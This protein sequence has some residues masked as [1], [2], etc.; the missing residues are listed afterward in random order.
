MPI[1]FAMSYE[2]SHDL[3]HSVQLA[4]QLQANEAELRLSEQRMSLAA[5]A[6]DLRLWEWDIVHD[7]IW[8][9]DKQRMLFGIALSEKISF[10]HFLSV[11]HDEDRERVRLSVEKS[12]KGNGHFES[13]YR[14]V[15]PDGRIIW[16][17]ARGRIE[18]DNGQPL[19]MLGV[20]IDIT[21]RKQAELEVQQQRNELTHLSRVNL[22]GELSGS[23]AHELNQPLAAILSNAQAAQRFLARDKADIA[24]V[25]DILKDIV[26]EDRRAGAII[27]RLRILLRKGEVRRLPLDVNKVVKDVLKLLQSDLVNQSI[28]V[29][30][31]LDQKLPVVNGDRVQLQQVLLN[32]ILNACEAMSRSKTSNRQLSVR[33]ERADTD[34]IKVSVG[35]RGPGISP[36]SLESIFQP[37]FTTKKQGMGLG[38]TICRNIISAHEGQLRASNSVGGGAVLHFTLPA[39][40]GVSV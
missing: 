15:Y 40:P 14:I 6:A 32:L 3:F 18:F 37:F 28:T 20:S 12:L 8:S 29:T 16:V 25:L 4:H 5:S 26:S 17:A 19:R 11:L 13:E 21:R 24:E 30:I 9:T 10:E 7:E 1:L 2:L 33:T 38:L 39:S 35:D 23:L 27:Q 31:D 34:L 36:E 22:L